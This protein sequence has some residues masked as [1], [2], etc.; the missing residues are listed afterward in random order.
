MVEERK[1]DFRLSCADL[2]KSCLVFIKTLLFVY[3][4][5]TETSF[6]KHHQDA[7]FCKDI[8]QS[9]LKHVS[10]IGKLGIPI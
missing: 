9:I 8:L 1:E 3:G 10:Q 4:E 7:I 6:H 5:K 2:Q